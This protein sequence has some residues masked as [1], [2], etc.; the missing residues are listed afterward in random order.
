[1]LWFVTASAR[2]RHGFRTDNTS[3]AGSSNQSAATRL[4]FVRKLTRLSYKTPLKGIL[5]DR[6]EDV[7]RGA[8]ALEVLQTMYPIEY[9]LTLL[10]SPSSFL[11]EGESDRW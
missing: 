2:R 7:D 11:P 4:L 1:M 3:H 8:D 5:I 9:D 6:R 10:D